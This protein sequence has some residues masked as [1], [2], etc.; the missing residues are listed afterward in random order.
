MY[1]IYVL[2]K[3]VGRP[4]RW[5]ALTFVPLVNIGLAA[6]LATDLAESFGNRLAFA[7][8]LALLP[9]LFVPILGYGDASY[10]RIR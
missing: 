9:V 7:V 5:L 10:R 8:G 4:T 2:L 1:N 6:V 3:L